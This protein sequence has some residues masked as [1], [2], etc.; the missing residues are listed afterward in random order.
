MN[1]FEFCETGLDTL[2]EKCCQHKK[3]IRPVIHKKT[4]NGGYNVNVKAQKVYV[5]RERRLDTWYVIL[6]QHKDFI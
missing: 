5:S 6:C 4:Q 1:I 3:F 2:R